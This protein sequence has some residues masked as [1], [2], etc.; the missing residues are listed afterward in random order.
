MLLINDHI[1]RVYIL[2]NGLEKLEKK[3]V[4]TNYVITIRV[5][6]LVRSIFIRQM[7]QKHFWKLLHMPQ[8]RIEYKLKI[9]QRKILF[10]GRPLL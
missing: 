10:L 8:N 2:E 5:H 9:K 4:K 6:W 3:C 7:S 1:S